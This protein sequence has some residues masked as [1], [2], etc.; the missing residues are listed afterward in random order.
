MNPYWKKPLKV[1]GILPPKSEKNQLFRLRPRFE[2]M[3]SLQD[4]IMHTEIPTKMRRIRQPI[5]F[6]RE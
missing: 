2:K 1:M 4:A 6:A 5:D 3:P